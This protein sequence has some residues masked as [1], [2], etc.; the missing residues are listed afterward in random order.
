M[1][2]M[3]LRLKRICDWD[4]IQYEDVYGDKNKKKEIECWIC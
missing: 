1:G 3:F 4:I 2:N